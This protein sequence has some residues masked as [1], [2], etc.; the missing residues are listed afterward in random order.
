MTEFVCKGC[1]L[2]CRIEAD[3]YGVKLPYFC[4]WGMDEV[5]WEEV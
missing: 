1:D 3:K 4:P 5:K 2:E